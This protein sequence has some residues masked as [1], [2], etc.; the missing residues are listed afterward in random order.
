MTV[1]ASYPLT[2][3]QIGDDPDELARLAAWKTANIE[4]LKQ[5]LGDGLKTVIEH[6]DEPHP[7]IHAYALPIDQPGVDAK[8]LHPGMVAKA[9]ADAAARREG[10]EPKDAVKA[11]NTAY[12]AA[13]RLW[14]DQYYQAVGAPSGLTRDGPRRAR[15]SRR[16]WREERAAA[17]VQ[18]DLMAA[19]AAAQAL[20]EARRRGL[21]QQ[22][23]DDRRA[24]RARTAKLNTR[25]ADAEQ[26]RLKAHSV[27][28]K[29]NAGR[30]A[31][32]QDRVAIESERE[33]LAQERREVEKLRAKLE[34]QQV[35]VK[36]IVQ[37]VRVVVNKF[38][39][40]FGLPLPKT[41]GAA[42]TALEQEVE[43]RAQE[44]EPEAPDRSAADDPGA[45][46]SM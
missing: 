33:T 10:A 40:Y 20:L 28:K 22:R 42:V 31:V 16:Q 25:E 30:S 12:V 18:A 24:A 46:F 44:L 17:R 32:D 9:E 37:R 15:K 19:Q 29:I 36:R 38:T 27:V 34:A 26:F 8:Q 21:V 23:W 4:H 35:G 1:V 13:M 5:I 11:G 2:H 7:H 6:T 14:Q 3:E 43:A 39:E 41:L 45:S